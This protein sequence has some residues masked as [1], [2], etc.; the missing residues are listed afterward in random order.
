MNEQGSGCSSVLPTIEVLSS[1]PGTSLKN[2]Q[3]LPMVGDE[4]DLSLTAYIVG[5]FLEAGLSLTFPA[6]RN[7]LFC[8]QE[9]YQSGVTNGYNHAILAYVFTIAGDEEKA[10]SLLKI[11]DQSATKT[12]NVIHWERAKK[13]KM[14]ESSSFLP[15]APSAEIEKTCYVLLAV[16][17][18]KIPDLV[19]ASKIVWWLAQQMNSHG[20]FSSTQVMDVGQILMSSV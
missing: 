1:I 9:A 4:K 7:G 8:L 5:A 10:E 13:P 17:S 12:N 14:E 3:Q 6:L 2:E 15:R 18:P 11:L 19:Y 16:I 20:G